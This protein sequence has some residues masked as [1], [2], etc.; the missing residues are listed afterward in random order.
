MWRGDPGL[1]STRREQKA[2]VFDVGEAHAGR[3][4]SQAWS[5]TPRAWASR[6]A[7]SRG[8]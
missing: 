5:S 7:I 2:A 8:S 1:L 6:T 4:L 3:A